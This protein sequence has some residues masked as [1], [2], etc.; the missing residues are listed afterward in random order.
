MKPPSK[1]SCCG[2][3]IKRIIHGYNISASMTCECAKIRRRERLKGCSKC[4]YEWAPNTYNIMIKKHWYGW[5]L[6]C[7]CGH[8]WRVRE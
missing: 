6:Y 8:K 3:E 1:C 7:T 2:K 4:G 5:L